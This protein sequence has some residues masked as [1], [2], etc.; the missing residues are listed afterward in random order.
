[1]HCPA[2]A[3][4]GG[5]PD[6]GFGNALGGQGYCAASLAGHLGEAVAAVAGGKAGHAAPVEAASDQQFEAEAT[7]PSPFP[8][9]KLI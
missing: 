2:L 9:V 4:T 7:S 1:M 6:P 3:G 8:R 5:V